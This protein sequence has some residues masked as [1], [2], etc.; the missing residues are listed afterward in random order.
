[1][2]QYVNRVSR[3]FLES[4]DSPVEEP[5]AVRVVI[6]V[7]DPSSISHSERMSYR[8]NILSTSGGE[9]RDVGLDED[10]ARR[11][12]EGRRQNVSMF[13][14]GEATM[15]P[16]RSGEQLAMTLLVVAQGLEVPPVAVMSRAVD[17]DMEDSIG[18]EDYVAHGYSFEPVNPEDF[19]PWDDTNSR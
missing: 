11:E 2:G 7:K 6:L 1:M 16:T 4:C 8:G 12:L 18:S 19:N 9:Y 5:V 3:L 13:L 10:S 17:E 14:H 15:I